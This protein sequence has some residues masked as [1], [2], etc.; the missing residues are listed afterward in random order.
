MVAESFSLF[1]P[2]WTLRRSKR[3]L[4]T[5]KVFKTII[6]D[7]KLAEAN[8]FKH[9]FTSR[10]WQSTRRRSEFRRAYQANWMD[11]TQDHLFR[12]QEFGIDA[13]E[14]ASIIEQVT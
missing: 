7:R 13:D 5:S 6:I 2:I 3:K 14:I 4:S 11:R 12:L 9:I 10:L 8:T 1:K